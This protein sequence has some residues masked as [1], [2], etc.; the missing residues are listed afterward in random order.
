MN[1]YINVKLTIVYFQLKKQLFCLVA[2]LYNS[3]YQNIPE[4]T[5]YIIRY[6]Y[7][8]YKLQLLCTSNKIQ[9]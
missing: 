8:T 1:P 3:F 2:K 5:I 9:I 7:N 6:Q 4:I